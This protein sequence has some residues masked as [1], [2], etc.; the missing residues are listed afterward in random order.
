M[1]SRRELHE[2][3]RPAARPAARFGP[4]VQAQQRHE[5]RGD[6]SRYSGRE[7]TAIPEAYGKRSGASSVPMAVCATPSA[8]RRTTTGRPAPALLSAL[9]RRVNTRVNAYGPEKARKSR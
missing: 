3:G 9:V 2:A 1:P 5:A 7:M 4:R 8:I 6:E